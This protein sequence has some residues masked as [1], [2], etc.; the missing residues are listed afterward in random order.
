MNTLNIGFFH[1]RSQLKLGPLLG[2]GAFG[3]VIQAEATGIVGYPG[4]TTVAV[5]ML[6]EG[7]TDQDMI[8]FVSEMDIMKI[9]SRFVHKQCISCSFFNM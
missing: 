3:K 7:H 9:I 2:E 5:K 8:D 1:N 6:K 4:T